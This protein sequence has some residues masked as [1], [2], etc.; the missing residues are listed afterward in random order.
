MVALSAY[1]QQLQRVIGDPRG[2]RHNLADLVVYVN[3]ARAQVA[4]EGQCVRVLPPAAGGVA[5]LIPVQPGSGY[6]PATTTVTV[7]APDQPW[8]TT[9]K[10]EAVITG[11]GSV[12]GYTVIDPGSGYSIETPLVTIAGAGTGATATSQIQPVM[13]T[14]AD[15]QE[16]Q[17]SDIPLWNYPAVQSILAI[18]N[19]TVI[20]T[21]FRYPVFWVSFSKFQAKYNPYT[22]GTFLYAPIIAC[23][24]GQGDQGT[25]QLSPVPNQVYPLELD[26]LGLPVDLID[27]ST[28]E[29]IP[30]PWTD[31]VPFYAAWLALQERDDSRAEQI[32]E[33]RLG[34]YRMMMR[35]ARAFSMPGRTLNPY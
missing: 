7:A 17:F 14:V 3:L 10:A 5:E 24:F 23:Q 15:Q 29:A 27:D 32:A 4:A 35:R 26:C 16:Y 31:A 13:T 21:N 9:A 18:R 20:W 33:K 25:F 28:P 34:S 8:G 22:R 6:A 30:Y 19:A 11:G 1:L 2:E 12:T